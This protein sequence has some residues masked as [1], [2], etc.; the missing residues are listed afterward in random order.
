[1]P[2][3]RVVIAD[4]HPFFRRGLRKVLARFDVEVVGEAANGWAAIRAVELTEPDVVVLD[5]NMPALSG[6]DTIRR[7]VDR[8]PACQ[9]LVLS[10]SA[11]ETDVVGAILAGASGY[12]LK[13]GPVEDVV[14]GVRTL[15]AGESLL[16]P[17]IAALLL[18]HIRDSARV[19]PGPPATRLS[20]PDLELLRLV[21]ERRTNAE[22]GGRLG[23]EPGAVGSQI[24]V[25]LDKLHADARARFMSRNGGI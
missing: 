22:I 11:D 19:K 12:V 4:D 20:P 13:D 15:A 24:S 16:S 14:A 8:A 1:V 10:V 3:V 6:T 25:V 9:V 2:P 17:R 5:L 21:A 18:Q 23:I 7:L